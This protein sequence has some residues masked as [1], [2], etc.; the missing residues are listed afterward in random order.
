MVVGDGGGEEGAAAEA[1]EWA[2]GLHNGNAE[3]G[4]EE[5]HSHHHHFVALLWM[6]SHTGG[7]KME[8]S[9]ANKGE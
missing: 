4:S 3:K 6:G 8:Y 1:I 9:I 2:D 5:H 7:N